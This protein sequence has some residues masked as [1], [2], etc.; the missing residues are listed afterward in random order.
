MNQSEKEEI[1]EEE[2]KETNREKKRDRVAVD[3]TCE[4]R[5]EK[6]YCRIMCGMLLNAGYYN[7]STW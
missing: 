2:D 3:T 5:G 6:I 4:R 7:I 1:R